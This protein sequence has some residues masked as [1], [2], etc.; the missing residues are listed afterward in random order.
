MSMCGYMTKEDKEEW[1]QKN[2]QAQIDSAEAWKQE[3]EA[4]TGGQ[5]VRS[6]RENAGR[7]GCVDYTSPPKER[8]GA[9]KPAGRDLTQCSAKERAAHQKAMSV[10]QLRA[11]IDETGVR[12]ARCHRS[13]ERRS[14][15]RL[16]CALTGSKLTR[17]VSR[18]RIGRTR[19]R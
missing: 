19:S 3:Q 9:P 18:T 8:P 7:N 16:L 11:R 4:K 17:T 12:S 14:A 2:R 10:S 13:L 1:Y 15:S 5:I 6:T